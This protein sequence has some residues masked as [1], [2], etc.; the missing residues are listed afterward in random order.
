V[1][2]TIRETLAVPNKRAADLAR[3]TMRQ[4][5]Y[6]DHVGLVVP[7]IRRQLSPR[8]IVRLYSFQDL[9]ELLVAAELRHQPGISQRQLQQVIAHLHER[10]CDAPLR[11]VRFATHDGD[12]YFQNPDGTW[13]GN[14]LPGWLI[15]RQ[16]I[17]LD[18][19]G[20]RIDMVKDRNPAAAG[21]ILRR[22]GA[23]GSIFAGT[24][25]PVGTVQRY[26]QAGYDTEAIIREYPALTPADVA[27]A[28]EYA[29]VS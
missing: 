5:R 1:A 18:L 12:I 27:A 7:S 8:T 6:W 21:K 20:D 2:E 16:A 10:D 28:R 24:S 11:E 22:R 23:Q 13:S 17:A 25:I 19:I 9:L 26:L 4:L 3:I 14:P 29:A 15:Y